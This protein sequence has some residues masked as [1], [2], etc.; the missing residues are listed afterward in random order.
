MKLVIDCFKLIKGN[1]KSIG[2]YNLTRNLVWNLAKYKRPQD[3]LIVLGTKYNREDFDIPGVKFVSVKYNPKNKLMCIVWEL[4][5][6]NT[7]L[8]KIVA[9]AVLFP[10]GFAPISK[11]TK[12]YVIIHDMIPFYYH[13]NHPGVLNRMENFYIMWRLK[14]SA[15]TCDMVLTDSVASKNEI[16][17]IAGVNPWKVEVVYPGCNQI[18]KEVKKSEKTDDMPIRTEDTEYISAI[19]SGLPHKNAK[20]V[21]ESYQKYY[22]LA[23]KPLSLVIIGLAD[24]EEYDLPKE[25]K[26]NILCYKFLEKDEDMFDIIRNSKMFLFL[27]KIEG[28]GFPPLEAMQLGVPVVCSNVSSVPEVTGEAAMLVNPEDTDAVAEAMVKISTD[29]NLC[30]KYVKKGFENVNRFEWKDCIEKYKKI[31]M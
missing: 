29:E 27:S 10:R 3:K 7:A 19:T 14:A 31:M 12:E 8:R 1:G 11:V 2:I 16:V 5:L 25:I 18:R 23:D 20:G 9:D 21:I 13:K 26:E 6:V 15:R 24:V 30:R 28:F 17:D 4:Y 22:K